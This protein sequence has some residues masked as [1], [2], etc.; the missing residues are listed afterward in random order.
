LDVAGNGLVFSQ[1]LD[2]VVKST[3]SASW[4]VHNVAFERQRGVEL[5]V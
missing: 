3:D 4:G 2:S 5:S 1:P